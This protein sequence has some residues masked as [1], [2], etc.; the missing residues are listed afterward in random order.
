MLWRVSRYSGPGFPSPTTTWA[1]AAAPASFSFPALFAASGFLRAAPGAFF[2]SAPAHGMHGHPHGDGAVGAD[3]LDVHVHELFGHGIELH[4]ADDGHPRAA[5]ALDLQREQL[6]GALV[7]V[8]DAQHVARVDGDGL[9]RGAAI[10]DGGHGARAAQAA[11]DALA[12]A[13]TALDGDFGGVHR[14]GSLV[15]VST[16]TGSRRIPRRGSAEWP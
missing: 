3:L 5:I 8:D 11:G 14:S 7:A 12:R 2:R 16:R 9:R 6:R 10:E 13:L 15:L 4:V 1:N